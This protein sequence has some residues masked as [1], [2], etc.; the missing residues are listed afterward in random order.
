MGLASAVVDVE[1]LVRARFNCVDI[2]QLAFPQIF[3][4][5]TS[6]ALLA[7]P[8]AQVNKS[9]IAPLS[10]LFKLERK[11]SMSRSCS[12]N[13]G[14][15]SVLKRYVDPSVCGSESQRK[16]TSLKSE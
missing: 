7:L 11:A 8:H 9:N 2:D 13:V 5:L 6:R 15:R 3:L 16:N 4:G 12:W 14:A 1:L 10:L